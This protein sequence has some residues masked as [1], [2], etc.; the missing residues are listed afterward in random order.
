[1]LSPVIRL[2]YDIQV[3]RA[4][5]RISSGLSSTIAIAIYNYDAD[6]RTFRMVPGTS[7]SFSGSVTGLVTRTL[8]NPLIL[9][10]EG[11]YWIA[12]R[13]TSASPQ[14]V[15]VPAAANMFDVLY[16]DSSTGV[17]PGTVNRDSLTRSAIIAVPAVLYYADALY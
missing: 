3:D 8:S 5:L 10:P 14:I 9:T 2:P 13:I 4:Q 12:F 1:V 17:L 6:A 15:S 11:N 16:L 7:D